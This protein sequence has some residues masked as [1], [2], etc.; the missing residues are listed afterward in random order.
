LTIL[1]LADS[2]KFISSNLDVSC[3]VVEDLDFTNNINL[4]AVSKPVPTVF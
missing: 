1:F 4:G 2:R 3:A